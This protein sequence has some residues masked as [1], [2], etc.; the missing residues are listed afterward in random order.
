MSRRTASWLAWS[1]WAMCVALIVL[2]LLL[3]F[4]TEEPVPPDVPAEILVGSAL[5]VLTALLSLAYLTVGA[6]IASRLPSNPIGWIFCG[7]GLLYETRRFTTAYANYGL[8]ENSALPGEL[9]VAWFSTW[10][11]DVGLVLA[12]VFLMLL[13]PEGR[14]LSRRWRIVAWAALC[15]SVLVALVFAFRPGPLR[16]TL[17]Y[18]ENPFEVIGVI[19]GRFTTYELFAASN[20]LGTALLGTSTLAAL[21]SLLL[22]LHRARGDERQQIK[23]FLFAAV[24]AAVCLSLVF[25]QIVVYD[26]TEEFLGNSVDILPWPLFRAALYVAVTA[27]LVVPVFAY[28]AILKYHLYDIDST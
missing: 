9:Y 5:A 17:Y 24:P 26:Y 21:F 6:L 19:G 13:F 3:D 12:G 8:L 23:W 2:G 27:L 7:V 10:A 22:R 11:G 4:V 20:V 1:L 15:G 25:I 18:V 14:L 16:G 28:I